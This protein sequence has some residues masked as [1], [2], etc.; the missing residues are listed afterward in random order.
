MSHAVIALTSA[1]ILDQSRERLHGLDHLRA[2]ATL[3]VL[4]FH[5]RA[6]YGIPEALIP[7]GVNTVAAFGW[8]GVDL[9]FVLSGYLIGTKLFEDIDN[10]GQV[11][12]KRFYLNRPFGFYR[13][14]S[15]P[16]RS[17]SCS[18]RSRKGAACTLVEV[19]DFYPEPPPGP[20]RQYRLTR[21]VA[22]RGGAFYLILPAILFLVFNNRWQRRGLYLLVALAALDVAFRYLNWVEFVEPKFGRRRLA[23]R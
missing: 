15:W 14:I 11:R 17:T 8:S 4:V 16:W 22:K 23:R 20:A 7:F 5:Y 10:H 9:F 18:V 3:L 12:F 19:P 6:Y 13:P 2:L 21:L 1:L